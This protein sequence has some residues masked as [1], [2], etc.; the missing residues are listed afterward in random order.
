MI[1]EQKLQEQKEIFQSI[2]SFDYM[3]VTNNGY[4][5]LQVIIKDSEHLKTVFS[6]IKRE[7][8]FN[9]LV[10]YKLNGV[11]SNMNYFAVQPVSKRTFSY[12]GEYNSP[13]LTSENSFGLDFD[14][15][16]KIYWDK[17]GVS[18]HH[19]FM[20][21]LNVDGKWEDMETFIK[22]G[23]D[24]NSEDAN[25]PEKC[26]NLFDIIGEMWANYKKDDYITEI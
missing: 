10:F 3:K 15:W 24:W 25:L 17:S 5:K 23:I 20:H 16:K 6:K 21:L 1:N 4:P 22:S 9:I 13:L 18:L 11:S 19:V 14:F 26:T 12:M 7:F 2:I 8:N